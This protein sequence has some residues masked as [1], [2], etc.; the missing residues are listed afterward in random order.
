VR[1]GYRGGRQTNAL[2]ASRVAIVVAIAEFVNCA[3]ARIV[4][5]DYAIDG[6]VFG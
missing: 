4:R 3:G 1:N 6:H 5:T 2:R